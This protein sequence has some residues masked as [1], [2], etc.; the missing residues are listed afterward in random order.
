MAAL[1]YARGISG[2]RRARTSCIKGEESEAEVRA[3]ASGLGMCCRRGSGHGGLGQNG[4]RQL[5]VIKAAKA[6]H[7]FK[8]ALEGLVAVSCASGVPL[9]G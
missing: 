6:N 7:S 4:M 1:M 5:R 8:C 2:S 9:R 3:G